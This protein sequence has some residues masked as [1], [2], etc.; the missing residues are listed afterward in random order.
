[1]KVVLVRF[2]DGQR[3]DFPLGDGPVVLGRRQDCDLRIPASNVS[4]QH[5]QIL[6][7]PKQVLVKDLGSANGTYVNGKR[8]AESK[9]TPGDRLI[10]GSVVFVVQID[11]QPASIK[12]ADAKVEPPAVAP[13]KGQKD[14]DVFELGEDDFDIDDAISALDEMDEDKDLP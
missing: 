13:A 14:D 2:K 12:A 11:G 1:M 3:R 4:R 9:L 8:V 10:V 5:C 6:I 7:Q